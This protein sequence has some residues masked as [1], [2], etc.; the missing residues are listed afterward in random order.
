MFFLS[1]KSLIKINGGQEICGTKKM[2]LIYRECANSFDINL[3]TGAKNN[4]LSYRGIRLYY[5]GL[6]SLIL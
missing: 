4:F 6:L 1:C 3:I 5:E 2:S